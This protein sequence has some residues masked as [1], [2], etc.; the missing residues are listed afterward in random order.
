MGTELELVFAPA[1]KISKAPL[2]LADPLLGPG[3]IRIPINLVR[4]LSGAA[5]FRSSRCQQIRTECPVIDKLLSAQDGC[6]P[7]KGNK[8]QIQNAFMSFGD[9]YSS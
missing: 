4:K 5:E 9:Q 8:T 6:A 7:P 2:V 3:V 1:G